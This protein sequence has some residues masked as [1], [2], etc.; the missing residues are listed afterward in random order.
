M[1]TTVK[2]AIKPRKVVIFGAGSTGRG[3]IGQLAYAS[4]YRLVFVDRDEALVQELA[5]SR[6]YTVRLVGAEVRDVTIQD[7]AVY[8]LHDERA[9]AEEGARCGLVLTAV[10]AE[11]LPG[12]AGPLSQGII[13]R[14]DLGIDSPLN[15]IACENMIGGSTALRGYVLKALDSSYHDYL[16]AHVG[17]PDAMISRVVPAP[18]ADK[19]FLEA[20]DYN[21]W[22]VDR[23][24]FLG[25]DPAVQGL[26]LVRNL[27]ALLERKL[28]MHNTGH[29][30]CGYLGYL[31]GYEVM[32]DA[33][34][35]PWIQ[36][37]VS[38]A[39]TESG[40]ALRRKHGFSPESIGE[41]REGFIPRVAGRLILDP[42][43]RVIRSP[44]REIGRK[45]RLIGP[46]CMALDY[47]IQPV[48]LA[49][50]IAALL[51][52]RS[53]DDPEAE[54]LQLTLRERGLGHVLREVAGVDPAAYPAL[55]G[56]IQ[57]AQDELCSM[58]AS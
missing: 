41:Y 44:W 17:F 29:A 48:N 26:C 10:L 54:E 33:I 23:G 42:V 16:S 32:C 19:L 50:G 5:A 20:E 11:N 8:S 51:R 28:Y 22:P 57:A 40:E 1:T 31:K 58:G 47:G 9:I 21:E 13:R 56:L 18:K 30:V 3:H 6:R 37:I 49:L 7:I 14:A 15:V 4:G 12:V 34:V 52:Y 46:A 55:E 39:M 2:P 43:S 25:E 53:P 45:E 27:P 24:S 38:G 36:P 35:D